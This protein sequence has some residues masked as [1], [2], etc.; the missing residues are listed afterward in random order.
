MLDSMSR[1]HPIVA[2]D[3][4][5]WSF[6]KGTQQLVAHVSTG[7]DESEAYRLDQV[8]PTDPMAREIVRA[9]LRLALAN[10]DASEP[11]T[12]PGATR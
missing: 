10:L 3:E 8:S 9:L 5:E 4:I 6:P 2:P 7:D 12:T 1:T 11:T